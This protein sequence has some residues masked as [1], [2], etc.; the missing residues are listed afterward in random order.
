MSGTARTD[1][2]VARPGVVVPEGECLGIKHMQAHA[3]T[4]LFRSYCI[5]LC[6]P[7]TH[8]LKYELVD[9]KRTRLIWDTDDSST[10]PTSPKAYDVLGG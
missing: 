6:I 4:L 1:C 5:Y 9:L 7:Y 2:R 10:H 3:G 8:C